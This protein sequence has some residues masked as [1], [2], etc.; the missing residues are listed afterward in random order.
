MY[1]YWMFYVPLLLFTGAYPTQWGRT[2][3]NSHAVQF[4]KGQIQ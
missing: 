2:I 1:L 4:H 3:P